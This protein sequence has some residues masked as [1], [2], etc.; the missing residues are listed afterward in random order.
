MT[1]IDNL[2]GSDDQ[3]DFIALAKDLGSHVKIDLRGNPIFG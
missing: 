3:E 1:S 2:F